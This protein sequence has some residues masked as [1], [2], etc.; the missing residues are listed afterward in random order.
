MFP[1]TYYHHYTTVYTEKISAHYKGSTSQDL[2]GMFVSSR[3]KTQEEVK[4]ANPEEMF[5]LNPMVGKSQCY[6]LKVA[7]LEIFSRC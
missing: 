2:Q 4:L 5:P 7:R 1:R 3:L 6:S